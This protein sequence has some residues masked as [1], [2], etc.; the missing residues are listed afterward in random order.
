MISYKKIFHFVVWVLFI[1]F[2][3]LDIAQSFGYYED[4]NSKKTTLTEEKIKK[5]EKDVKSGK[6]IKVE[7]YVVDVKK[8]FSNNV[9][10]FG[11]YTSNTFAKYFK[12]S[13]NKLFGEVNKAVNEE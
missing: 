13:M 5:F 7:N 3:V 2:L 10:S 12:W 6:K 4:I 11:L 8:D 9:S 1:S